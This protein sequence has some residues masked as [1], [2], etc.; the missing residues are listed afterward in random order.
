MGTISTLPVVPRETVPAMALT[1]SEVRELLA[2]HER[3]QALTRALAHVQQ[4]AHTALALNRT[5]A[6]HL[7][8]ALA[9]IRNLSIGTR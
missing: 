5:N 1:D 9:T 2:L 3:E 8:K 4:L 6:P 7:V